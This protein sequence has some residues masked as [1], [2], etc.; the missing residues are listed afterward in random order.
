MW[1]LRSYRANQPRSLRRDPTAIS[2]SA[3]A[4]TAWEGALGAARQKR[5]RPCAAP[6]SFS[7]ALLIG[8][9]TRRRRRDRRRRKLRSTGSLGLGE[10]ASD[11]SGSSRSSAEAIDRLVV[12]ADTVTLPWSR[13]D[14]EQIPGRSCV[15]Y[16]STR[17]GESAGGS[18][19]HGG[20][21]CSS[22]RRGRSVC[23]S[24]GAALLEQA[25]WSG[26]GG[27]TRARRARWRDRS[28]WRKGG[29]RPGERSA[30]R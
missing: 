18:I 30:R 27:R 23:R 14:R 25:S 4:A 13:D 8:A 9:T 11:R 12:L 21:S 28:P 1:R 29:A 16:S 17:H 20:R 24:P 6:V 15:R 7:D 3:S 5:T 10:F 2:C 26:K 22:G 19:K